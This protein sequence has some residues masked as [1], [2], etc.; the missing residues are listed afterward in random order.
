MVQCNLVSG[1]A[2]ICAGHWLNTSPDKNIK[3]HKCM[4]APIYE[5]LRGVL[6]AG[7]GGMVHGFLHDGP[8]GSSLEQLRPAI[9]KE[10]SGSQRI[11]DSQL[12]NGAWIVWLR[13]AGHTHG[14]SLYLRREVSTCKLRAFLVH[15]PSV[16]HLLPSL[17]NPRNFLHDQ[18]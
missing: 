17:V 16:H 12:S 13:D 9:S 18:A 10:Q 15:T 14:Y 11:S 7:S 6:T 4:T 3:F 8:Y 2:R 1:S 5:W